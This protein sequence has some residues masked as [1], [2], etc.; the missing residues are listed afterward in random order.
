MEFKDFICDKLKNS[1]N[2]I[3]KKMFGSYNICLDGVNLGILCVD[4]WYLKKTI[5]G[6]AFLAEKGLKIE[7][8]IKNKSYI[9]IDFSNEKE[10]CELV[11]IT[12]DE[13]VKS[14]G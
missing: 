9:V 3:A 2:V 7:T 8:G 4:K 1:G 10:L 13:I 12:L 6:D 11:I 5:A 14:K